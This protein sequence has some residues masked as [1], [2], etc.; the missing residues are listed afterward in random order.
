VDHLVTVVRADNARQEIQQAEILWKRVEGEEREKREALLRERVVYHRWS[1]CLFLSDESERKAADDAGAARELAELAVLVAQLL[2][3]QQPA[4]RFFIRL[5]GRAEAFLANTLRVLGDHALSEAGFAHAWTL[6]KEG[7]DEA[8][9]LSEAQILDL[10]ASLR[11]DQGRFEAALRLNAEALERARPE[12]EGTILLNKAA[13]LDLMG[14]HEGALAAF[15]RAAPLIDGT[16]HPRLRWV[17]RQNQALSLVRLGRV[18]EARSAVAEA[19]NLAGTLRNGLDLLRTRV[20]MALVDA[21]LGKTEE[22]IESLEEVC[23]AF[24]ERKHAFDYALVGL[25]LALLYRE[26]RRWPEIRE[27]ASRMIEI[28]R[29]R[30]IHRE[31]VAAVVLFQEAAAKEAVSVELVRRLQVYLKQAQARPGLRFEL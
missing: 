30:K 6:W 21:G 15:D 4:D 14:N 31:A 1:V 23:D 8:G 20:V 13:T 5:A 3:G 26:E 12:E 22:A 25:D 29:E 2:R 28:F 7:A 9:L 27:L 19:R 24:R 10:E 17:L 16:R 18:E 11:K